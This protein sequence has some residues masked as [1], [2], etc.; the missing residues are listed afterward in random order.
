MKAEAKLLR[1]EAE[2]LTGGA[3]RVVEQAEAFE[4]RAEALRY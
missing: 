2:I 3:V 1:R 4:M